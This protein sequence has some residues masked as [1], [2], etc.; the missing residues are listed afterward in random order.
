M[1]LGRL[2]VKLLFKACVPLIAVTGVMTYGVY[3]RGGDPAAMWKHV[4]SGAFGQVGATLSK[5]KND[6]VGV[7]GDLAS[8]TGLSSNSSRSGTTQVFTWK[9]AQ[10]VTHFGTSAPDD[11]IA[12]TVTVDPNVNV[13]VPVAAPATYQRDAQRQ[14]HATGQTGR[15]DYAS[16]A[17]REASGRSGGGSS[18]NRAVEQ[19]E[20]ELGE[21]LPGIA[22]QILSNG[23]SGGNRVDPSQL[24]RLL[25]SE[26]N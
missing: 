25:Q 14:P 24:I 9:D 10:G 11:A 26:G 21:P 12:S 6:A 20:S 19:L 2:V 16:S 1:M 23:A 22:G 7:A 4:A 8:N 5:A 18:A 13:V 17:Q 3:L 15:S